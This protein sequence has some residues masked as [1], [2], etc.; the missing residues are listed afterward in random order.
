[1]EVLRNIADGIDDMLEFTFNIPQNHEDGMLPILDVK[2]SINKKENN[3]VDFEFYDKPTKQKLVILCNSAIPASQKR[4]I[5]TQE[6]LRRMRNTK[7]ELGEDIQIKYLNEFMLK[8]KNSGYSVE[9]RKKIL[10]SASNAFQKM[11]DDD[12]S[13]IKPMYRGKNWKKE[14]REENKAARKLNWYKT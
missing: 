14:E 6:C 2:A 7:I 9:Y 5:L 4:T 1:M 11:K 12:K 13:G 3:R 8:L 10:D